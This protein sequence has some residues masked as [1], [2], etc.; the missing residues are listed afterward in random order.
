MPHKSSSMQVEVEAACP[1]EPTQGICWGNNEYSKRLVYAILLAQLLSVVLAVTGV[2][3]ASLA[4]QGV[5]APTIQAFFSYCLLAIVYGSMQL[6]LPCARQLLAHRQAAVKYAALGTASSGGSRQCSTTDSS[7]FQGPCS[8]TLCN[9]NGGGAGSW[10]RMTRMWPA[11]AALALIDV[12][13]NVLVVK[14]YQYTSLT[15]VTLLDCFTIPSV[16]LLSWLVLHSRYRPGH[17]LGAALCVCGL[18]VLVL[19]DVRSA[20]PAAGTTGNS[21]L[22]ALG[23]PD[24]RAVSSSTAQQHQVPSVS[25]VGQI[26]AGLLGEGSTSA[27]ISGQLQ[28]AV[29]ADAAGSQGGGSS[30]SAGSAPLLGDVLVLLGALLYSVCNVTQE[31]ILGDVR[32][33]EMLAGIGVFGAGLAGLQAVLLGEWHSLLSAVGVSQWHVVTPMLGFAC[34]M[35]C[36]YSLVP[37]VLMLGGAAVLNISLL[38]SDAWA[39]LARFL[40][41]G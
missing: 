31:L 39:A 35:L 41:F 22:A 40:W 37:H 8:H 29:L 2:S 5:H 1:A 32:P 25:T 33:S 9:G 30:S 3:S 13:A 20:V 36:F 19:G 4:G 27:N 28:Q 21:S 12:E 7:S 16:M 23:V 6:L 10:Q 24:S 14:A 15:S 11:F 34:A 26:S 17:F 18:A 38:S